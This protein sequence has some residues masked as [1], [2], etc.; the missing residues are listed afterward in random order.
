MFREF[1]LKVHSR[2]NLACGHCYMYE[3]V[4][5]SW[6]D[7]PRVMSSETVAAVGRNIADY[8]KKNGF[9]SVQL[10]LHGGEPLLLGPTRFA[11]VVT[12]L[13]EAIEPVATAEF[14]MQT[15]GIRL[16]EEWLH[17]LTR[18]QVHTG[19]SLDGGR[20]AND[21]HRR[22]RRGAS[23]YDQTVR[24]VRL[25]AKY[26]EI[27][28]GLLCTVDVRNDPVQT[29]RDLAAF[30]PPRVNVLLPHATHEFPPP[31]REPGRAI[32]GEWL[33]AMFDEWFFAP[34]KVGV[35]LFEELANAL[36]GG[37]SRSEAI[38]LGVPS[39]VVIET[40]GS[41]EQTDALKVTYPGAAAT[42]L[43]VRDHR[44]DDVLAS[45]AFTNSSR[46]ED[47]SAT[48]QACPVVRACGGGLYPHR[49]RPGSGFDNPSVYC[50]DLA[51]LVEHVDR[52]LREGPDPMTTI[53]SG[54]ATTPETRDESFVTI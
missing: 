51:Y 52:R 47:L 38:G 17:L 4:D 25:L 1:V 21:R 2:C 50:E 31:H 29:F 40:D 22:Y 45:G 48:C 54:P 9:D 34:P 43:N 46:L 5:Q 8:T 42:G 39:T 12:Q 18:H 32:Y 16:T 6:R 7:Q 33:A 26:P 19:I 15:N 49:Y 24:G 11:E 37:A 13:Q 35:R 3:A 14:G 20:E 27:Y 10:I 36:L 53:L 28:A 44:L 41:F 23:S 30:E